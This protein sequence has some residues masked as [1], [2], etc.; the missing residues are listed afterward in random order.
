MIRYRIFYQAYNFYKISAIMINLKV[1]IYIY[2]LIR[3][4]IKYKKLFW[5][6]TMDIK[7]YLTKLKANYYY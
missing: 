7:L 3:I 6:V 4:D 1:Y 5:I 2:I